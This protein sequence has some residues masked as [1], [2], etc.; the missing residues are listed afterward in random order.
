MT[1]SPTALVRLTK[2]Q[3]TRLLERIGSPDGSV[4]GYHRP[5][6][7]S[8]EVMRERNSLGGWGDASSYHALYLDE[9]GRICCNECG[10]VDLVDTTKAPHSGDIGA[11]DAS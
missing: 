9:Y 3:R 11:D 1:H 6:R 5:C 4:R 10:A 2:R 7:P 8:P